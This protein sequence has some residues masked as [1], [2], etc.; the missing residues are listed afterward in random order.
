MQVAGGLRV[1]WSGMVGSEGN[2]AFLVARAALASSSFG[3]GLER[4]LFL[5]ASWV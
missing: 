4:V 2:I 3:G 1:G 5:G